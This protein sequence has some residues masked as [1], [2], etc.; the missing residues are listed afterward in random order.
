[1]SKIVLNNKNNNIKGK[2]WKVCGKIK[3]KMFILKEFGD[4]VKKLD[5]KCLLCWNFVFE[6]FKN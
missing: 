3:V 5:E 6:E 4:F 2:L 1:M